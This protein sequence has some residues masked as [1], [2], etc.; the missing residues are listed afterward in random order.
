MILHEVY[1]Q[2][3]GRGSLANV[4]STSKALYPGAIALLWREMDRL[5]PLLD[6]IPQ[7]VWDYVQGE[8]DKEKV[9]RTVGVSAIILTLWYIRHGTMSCVP[10]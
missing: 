9:R 2:G 10:R 8:V 7:D 5:D 3:D 1:R 4:A 6:L